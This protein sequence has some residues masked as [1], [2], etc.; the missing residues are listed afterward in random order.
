MSGFDCLFTEEPPK[1][2]QCYCPICL[3]ILREPF[4]VDCC[5]KSFCRACIQKIEAK[6]KSCPTCNKEKFE[7]IQ[8]LGLQQ[9]LYGFRVFCSNKEGG[10]GWQGEL[11][12][13]D[14]HLNVD[15]H[16]DKQFVGC[17][18][19][20]LKCLFCGE[21]HHRSE[22]EEHQTSQCS[23]RPFTC[24]MCSEYES[25]Y[26]DVVTS[27][28]PEC[29]CRPVECPNSCG[30][31]DLQHQHLEEHVSSQCPLTPVEFEFSDAG[32]DAKVYRRDLPS[33][34]SDNMVTHMSLLARENRKLK[35]QLK[36]QEQQLKAQ[37]KT[38]EQQLREEL[39]RQ[40]AIQDKQNS[41]MQKENL[42]HILRVPPLFLNFG[43]RNK[44]EPFYSHA[45]GYK[46]QL[47]TKLGLQ[48][49]FTLLESEFAV[50]LPC[51]LQITAKLLNQAKDT[52]HITVKYTVNSK[53][54]VGYQALGLNNIHD[55]YVNSNFKFQIIDVLIL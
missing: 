34:L 37:L 5:G 47:E 36:T 11:G 29:K 42:A 16:Q 2:L 7:F 12:Q 30:A 55:Y 45:G 44:S 43:L 49:K 48:L 3:L 40:L 8:N 21:L 38:Q 10:C 33:H 39:K 46:L 41:K 9:P 50:C 51:K 19:I 24:E 53:K 52:D 17:A 28:A 31:S 13:L 20:N 14:K 23:Q 4:L 15:P 35:K 1:V 18:Y 26:E 6:K 32:C 27:H 25:T 54:D 22:M